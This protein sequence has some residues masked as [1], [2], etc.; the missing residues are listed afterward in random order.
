MAPPSDRQNPLL[1]RRLKGG[2]RLVNPRTK[3]DDLS[4]PPKPKPKPGTKNP[5]L[6]RRLRPGHAGKYKG[7]KLPPRK[8][9]GNSIRHH[10]GSKVRQDLIIP[11]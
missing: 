4:P 9:G 1:T 7:L 11:T 3:Y 2:S 10:F 5:L 8:Q 6:I